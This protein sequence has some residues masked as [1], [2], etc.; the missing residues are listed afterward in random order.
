MD[1]FFHIKERGSSVRTEVVGGTV[2]FLSM[3]YILALQPSMMSAAGML[4]AAVFTA[5]AISAAL[6]TVVMA[7]V[8]NVPIALASGLGINAFVAFTLCRARGYSDQTA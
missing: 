8:A 4:P 5:T 7:F 3:V 2:T 1:K 6:A